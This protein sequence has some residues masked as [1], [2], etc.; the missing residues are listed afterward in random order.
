MPP[1]PK[2]NKKLKEKKK[3]WDLAKLENGFLIPTFFGGILS[4]GQV[5][6]LKSA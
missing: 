2:K 4:L 1:P 5:C 3:I 6:F